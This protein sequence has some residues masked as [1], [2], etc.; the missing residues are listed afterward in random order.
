MTAVAEAYEADYEFS[1]S[2][3]EMEL[4]EEAV[5][6]R[7]RP[8]KKVFF[9]GALS[10]ATLHTPKGPATLNLPSPVPTLTQFRSLEQTVN[11]TSARLNAVQTA[12]A[13]ITREVGARRRDQSGQTSM[14]MMMFTL[15]GQKKLRDD[16]AGHTHVGSDAKA[17]LPTTSSSGSSLT[18]I[19][20]FILLMQ[21]NAFGGSTTGQDNNAMGGLLPIL[22]ISTIL[23]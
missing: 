14:M 7:F 9:P 5:R 2:F 16:L 6:G 22:L 15:L 3:D 17:V 8:A 1:E 11:G 12:L 20:P 10:S 19:L 4:T 23:D 18:S 13:R 21:P